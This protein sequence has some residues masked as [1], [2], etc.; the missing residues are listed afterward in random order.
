M[1]PTRIGSLPDCRPLLADPDDLTLVFRPVV[2]LAKATVAGYEALARFPGTASPDTWFAAAADAGLAAEVEALLVH[3]VLSR[4]PW[5]PAGRVLVVPVHASLL[6]TGPVRDAFDSRPRLDGL[7]VEVRPHASADADALARHTAPLRARGA[8]LALAGDVHPLSAAEPPSVVVIDRDAL[9]SAGTGDVPGAPGVLADGIETPQ[10]LTAALQ[11]GAALARGWLFGAPL[12]TFGA[13]PSAVTELVRTH[14]ARTRLVGPVLP[15]VRPVQRVL[16]PASGVA[17]ALEVDPD[18]A[19]VALVVAGPAEST[20]RKPI[21][22][23]VLP[24]APAGETLRLALSRPAELR[25]DPVLCVDEDGRPLGIVH[26]AELVR[27]TAF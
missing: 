7:V 6:A 9:T 5:V 14:R 13:L 23:R 15:L 18:G 27:A 1:V 25:H 19:P 10:D 17:P 22:L 12:A 20:W 21:S 2:D 11:S 8:R 26:V 24:D 3:K 4:L 16:A